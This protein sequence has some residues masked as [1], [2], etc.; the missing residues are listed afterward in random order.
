[1]P[2]GLAVKIEDLDKPWGKFMSDV[3]K[4]WMKSGKLLELEKKWVGSNTAWLN[5]ATA[6]AKK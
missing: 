1:M 3:I 6:A 2:W 5:E 4:D